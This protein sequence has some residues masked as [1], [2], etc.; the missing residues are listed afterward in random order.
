MVRHP[1]PW[2]KVRVGQ[3][4]WTA[5]CVA[6]CQQHRAVC[7]WADVSYAFDREVKYAELRVVSSTWRARRQCTLH[8]FSFVVL[9]NDGEVDVTSG[10]AS[11][12]ALISQCGQIHVPGCNLCLFLS[13]FHILHG[14]G[15]SAVPS[16]WWMRLH[17]CSAHGGSTSSTSM[18]SK[19]YNWKRGN[20]DIAKG[21]LR[22]RAMRVVHARP[23]TIP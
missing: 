6:E 13:P 14:A 16:K 22:I 18:T 15:R 9:F 7:E 21:N 12:T 10:R 4:G 17:A 11:G 3:D 20:Q 2:Q 23:L 19:L 8:V 5:T 1:R